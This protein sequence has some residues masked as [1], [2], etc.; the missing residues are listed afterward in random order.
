MNALPIST[1]QSHQ[2]NVTKKNPEKTGTHHDQIKFFTELNSNNLKKN[3]SIKSLIDKIKSFFS[4]P[5][6][7]KETATTI[8]TNV[9]KLQSS[10]NVSGTEIITSDKT[11]KTLINPRILSEW[12]YLF[13]GT[14]KV[15]QVLSHAKKMPQTELVQIKH[16][17]DNDNNNNKVGNSQIENNEEIKND[18]NLDNDAIHTLIKQNKNTKILMKTNNTVLTKL[19]TAFNR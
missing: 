9:I 18:K 12:L 14:V 5:K 13:A 1:N 4:Q 8:I 6:I 2:S 3:T 11:G 10:L 16:N 19:E 7:D 17:N 15:D